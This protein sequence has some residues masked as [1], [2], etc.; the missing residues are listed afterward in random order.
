[1]SA[2]NQNNLLENE[3]WVTVVH[4]P[5]Q[6]HVASRFPTT[7]QASDDAAARQATFDEQGTGTSATSMNESELA[8]FVATV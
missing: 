3:P 2:E 6:A 7:E 8:D 4:R 1:M 5:G